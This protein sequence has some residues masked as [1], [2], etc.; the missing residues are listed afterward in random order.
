MKHLKEENRE[1]NAYIPIKKGIFRD[2][3]T[4][5]VSVEYALGGINYFTGNHNARGY[6]VSFRPMNLTKFGKSFTLLGNSRESGGYIMTEEANR[7]SR[8][9]LQEIATIMDSRVPD[10]VNAFIKDDI[11]L[12]TELCKIGEKNELHGKKSTVSV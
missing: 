11:P 7:F 12:L 4:V 8:K 3:R 6:R 1:Y 5:E 10:I 2:Y 9:R